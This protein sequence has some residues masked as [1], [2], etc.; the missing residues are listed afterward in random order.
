MISWSST[1]V[2]GHVHMKTQLDEH[3]NITTDKVWPSLPETNISRLKS[4]GQ[5]N[6]HCILTAAHYP[7]HMTYHSSLHPKHP[8]R[9]EQV[10]TETLVLHINRVV[11][12][13]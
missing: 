3:H 10:V 11:H 1:R 8:N 12:Q 9:T 2:H 7:K 4:T 5:I 13:K 6:L